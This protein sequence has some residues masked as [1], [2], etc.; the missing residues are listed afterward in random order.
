MHESSRVRCY[1]L[2]SRRLL[3]LVK[4]KARVASLGK[5]L[6]FLPPIS[7]FGAHGLEVFDVC[8]SFWFSRSTALH[9][10]TL[11]FSSL[12]HHARLVKQHKFNRDGGSWVL[13]DFCCS[14]RHVPRMQ[15]MA[16][17]YP[18]AV[19]VS[20]SKY[21]YPR[22]LL[23]RTNYLR[24]QTRKDMKLSIYSFQP[25]HMPLATARVKYRYPKPLQLYRIQ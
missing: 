23:R 2:T 5:T 13:L 6:R 9:F 21:T 17:G 14:G 1:A 19:V 16:F 4:I 25:G 7:A 10:T 8:I 15:A 11:P 3:L 12:I 22:Q 18:T 24:S 20:P